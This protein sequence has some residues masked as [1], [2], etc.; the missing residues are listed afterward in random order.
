[1]ISRYLLSVARSKAK[2]QSRH[3]RRRA[4]ERYALDLHQDAQQQ[5]I[6]MIQDGEARFIR[7]Q[8][9]RVSLWEVEHDGLRLPIVY[10][11]KRKTIVTVL[12][13]EELLSKGA[14]Y[15]RSQK[16]V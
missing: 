8:S 1:L 4:R 11:R 7:R 5:I 12:P 9:Q 6:R 15:E 10:D 13:Q 14:N 3:A 2:K 16:A